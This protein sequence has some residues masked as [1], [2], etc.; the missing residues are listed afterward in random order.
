MKLITYGKTIRSNGVLSVAV[1][2]DGDDA[3]NL[4]KEWCGEWSAS[5]V[6]GAEIGD[7]RLGSN[8]TR[9]KAYVRKRLT[10]ASA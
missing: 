8:L 7:A 9:A 4:I 6:E 3:G 10:R 1:R 2:V 5:G